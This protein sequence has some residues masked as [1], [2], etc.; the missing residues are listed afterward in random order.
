[1]PL[2][3]VVDDLLGHHHEQRLQHLGH[4]PQRGQDQAAAAAKSR[5]ADQED[6]RDQNR[7]SMIG[8]LSNYF[9]EWHENHQ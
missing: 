5:D 9:L 8:I 6:V 2:V 4:D 3:V 1:M 7:R